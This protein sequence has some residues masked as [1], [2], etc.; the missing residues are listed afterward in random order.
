[1]CII[2]DATVFSKFLSEDDADMQ[3]VRDWIENKN[4]RIAYSPTKTFL[5]ELGRYRPMEEAIE[6]YHSRGKLKQIQ[7]E[8]VVAREKNL[9]KR[10]L[11][12]NDSHIIALAQE[13]GTTL[14]A[15]NDKHLHADF[16]N[17]ALIRR[18]KIYQTEKHKHLLAEDRCP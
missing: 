15:S 9:D 14:L 2:I 18:G 3:P 4:G 8:R 16:T 11:K 10:L 17:S 1:M 6:E 5:R 7:E 13:S 12:S